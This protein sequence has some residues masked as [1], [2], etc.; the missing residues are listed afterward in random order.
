MGQAFERILDMGLLLALHKKNG[1]KGAS[2]STG[3]T[4]SLQVRL[5]HPPVVIYTLKEPVL[6]Q[7]W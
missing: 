6:A 4:L 1:D 3:T 5:C 7:T 2:F